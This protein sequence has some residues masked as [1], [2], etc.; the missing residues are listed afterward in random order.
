M[1]TKQLTKAIKAIETNGAKR[2]EHSGAVRGGSGIGGGQGM[3]RIGDG[4]GRHEHGCNQWGSRWRRS[5]FFHKPVGLIVVM[6]IR[7]L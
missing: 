4:H 7:G 1:D 2:V 3:E 5:G 6:R